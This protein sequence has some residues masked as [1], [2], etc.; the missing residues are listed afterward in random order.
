[1]PS[2]ALNAVNS[3][4][5]VYTGVGLVIACVMSVF[6]LA[7]AWFMFRAPETFKNVE[8]T[9]LTAKCTS[10]PSTSDP[11]KTSFT[12]E[13]TVRYMVDDKELTQTMYFAKQVV[14]QQR[15]TIQYNLSN[16][17]EIR[18]AQLSPKIIAGILLVIA[19]ITLVVAWLKFYVASSV[20]G[21]G[22]AMMTLNAIGAV[23][24]AKR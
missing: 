5:K 1:M 3:V 15:I 11:Q 18:E 13:T 16:P 19:I 17:A 23:A 4:G 2:N 21:G 14:P 24:G 7:V 6:L 12:C 10:S 8:C 22:T 9:V 20:R